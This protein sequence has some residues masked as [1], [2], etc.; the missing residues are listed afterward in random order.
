MKLILV[1][2]V[3]M[4]TSQVV[5]KIRE[6]AKERDQDIECWA[7]MQSAVP[8]EFHKA[9]VILLGPH[10]A[11]YED[12]VKELVKGTNIKY[13]VIDRIDYAMFNGEKILDFANSL[14]NEN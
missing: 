9:D 7:I 13:G 14:Y 5:V 3:G 6:A 8:D 2:G 1:C 4:S 11:Y 10:I 12:N